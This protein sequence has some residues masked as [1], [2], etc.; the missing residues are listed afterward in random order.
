MID[1]DQNLLAPLEDTF[2]QPVNYRPA[3]AAAYDITGIFD[4]AYTQDV[5]PLD[6]GD[7]TINTTNPVLGVRDAAFRN[8]PQQGDRLYIPGVAQLFVVKDVQ[9]DSHGGSKLILNRVKTA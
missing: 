1:W 3:G 4:R 9:P 7:P 6:D 2:G 5:E 8:P